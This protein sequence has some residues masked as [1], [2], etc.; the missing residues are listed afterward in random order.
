MVV[1]RRAFARSFFL[2]LFLFPSFFPSLTLSPALSLPRS[3]LSAYCLPFS[4]SFFFFSV[5]Y[6][7]YF[8]PL[9][10]PLDVFFFRPLTRSNVDDGE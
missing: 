6:N 2:S 8:L 5:L 7:F 1:A 3:S 10:S 9:A 4:F